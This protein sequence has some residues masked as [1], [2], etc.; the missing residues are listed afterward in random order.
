M[1]IAGIL[2]IYVFCQK[3]RYA[4]KT[5][6]SLDLKKYRYVGDI[7]NFEWAELLKISIN[8]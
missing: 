8:I 6:I 3:C 2:R 1:P 7:F 5:Q 4:N